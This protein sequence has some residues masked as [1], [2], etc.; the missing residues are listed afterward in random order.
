MTKSYGQFCGL[1]RALDVVGDRWSLLIV[2]QLLVAPARYGELLA[3]LPGVATNLLSTRLR[4]LESAGVV[5]RRLARDA[6]AVEYTL[7]EWGSGLREPIDALIRWSEPLMIPGRGSDQFQVEWLMVALPALLRDKQSSRKAIN[8]GFAVDDAIVQ[9]QASR[10]GVDVGLHDGRKLAA[11]LRAEPLIALGLA[12]GSLS[13][14][15]VASS[16][17]VEGDETALRAVLAA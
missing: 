6:N 12:A 13:L 7:T 5:E 2:R 8:I 17:S 14:D 11:I 15:D 9:V 16:V 3:G 10:S 1:A 4:D